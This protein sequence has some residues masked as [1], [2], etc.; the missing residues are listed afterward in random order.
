MVVP[1]RDPVHQWNRHEARHW[2]RLPALSRTQGE[3][4]SSIQRPQH[5]DETRNSQLAY[6]YTF[7]LSNRSKTRTRTSIW[8]CV[9]RAA[10]IPNTEA[11]ACPTRAG[12]GWM[13]CPK[14]CSSASTPSRSHHDS[15]RAYRIL[16]HAPYRLHLDV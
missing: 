11:S 5:P 16:C 13:S 4:R 12:S 6:L 9:G 10:A 14:A 7:L 15:R 2:T 8:I 1:A 3:R